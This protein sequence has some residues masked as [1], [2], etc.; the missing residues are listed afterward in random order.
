MITDAIK[1]NIQ[2]AEA[3]VTAAERKY[4]EKKP[5]RWVVFGVMIALG[6]FLGIEIPQVTNMISA[7]KYS[8]KSLDNVMHNLL[9]Q[10]KFDNITT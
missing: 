10:Y 7:S 9:G 8:R 5:C 3:N 6:L 2:M 4:N 1:D